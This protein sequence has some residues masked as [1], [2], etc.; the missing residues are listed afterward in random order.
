MADN[1]CAAIT[2][3]GTRCT[4]HVAV[5]HRCNEHHEIV[6]WAGPSRVEQEEH[7][8]IF[9]H[10]KKQL[11]IRYDELLANCTN[12]E[13]LK[14]LRTQYNTDVNDLDFQKQADLV[15]IRNNIPLN[16]ADDEAARI[17]RQEHHA[18][19]MAEWEQHRD[20]YVAMPA[21]N[22]NPVVQQ[23]IVNNNRLLNV[24]TDQQSVHT[25]VVVKNVVNK[26]I[27]K[28]LKIEVPEEYRWNTKSVSKT[29]VEIMGKCNLSVLAA[30][31]LCT[32]YLSDDNI[33]NLGRG[34]YGRTLDGVWQ[35]IINKKDNEDMIKVLKQELEDNIGKCS[36]GQL[37]RICN[38]L[39]GYIEGVG[40]GESVN[41]ILGREFSKLM[42]IE[43]ITERLSKGIKILEQ[44]GLPED[45]WSEWL[46]PL[47]D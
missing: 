4:R 46:K 28:L 33:Y 17:R 6:L 30:R 20:E 44:N 36:Q 8:R 37:T 22:E 26:A 13:E 19:R 11:K 32:K 39:A 14:R 25:V 23:T 34:I 10:L 16:A 41:E 21:V 38:I 18:Q 7:D 31:D 42:E 12:P 24:A 9:K 47:E 2:Y 40:V 29:V 15:H 43:T 5:N 27:D 3:K 1:R 45:K 35:Y